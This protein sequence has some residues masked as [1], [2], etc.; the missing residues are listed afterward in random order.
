MLRRSQYKTYDTKFKHQL[1]E[2]LLAEPD[3]QIKKDIKKKY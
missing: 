3:K 1:V 2:M